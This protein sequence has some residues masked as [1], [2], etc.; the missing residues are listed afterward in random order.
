LR[1]KELFIADDGIAYEKKDI[2]ASPRIGVDYA[3]HDAL[4][5]YRFYIKGS[6]Y[7]SG[8]PK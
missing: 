1:S 3:G 7:L 8:K 6:P 4:L 2:I 5:P